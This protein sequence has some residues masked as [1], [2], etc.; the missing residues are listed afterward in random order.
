MENTSFIEITNQYR[1]QKRHQNMF[2]SNCSLF[3]TF[4]HTTVNKAYCI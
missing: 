2:I 3:L 4:E 1:Q